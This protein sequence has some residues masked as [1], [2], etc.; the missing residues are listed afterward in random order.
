M[1]LIIL[2]AVATAIGVSGASAQ[3]VPSFP[4]YYRVDGVAAD[5]V[6]NIRAEPTASAPIVG[7]FP[8]DAGPVE[9]L[10]VENGWALV[11]TGEAMGWTSTSYLTE[12]DMPLIGGSS[13]PDGL[14]C[15]GTEPFWSLAFAGGEAIFNSIDMEEAQLSISRAGGFAGVGPFRAYVLASDGQQELTAIMGN[16][17][18]SDGMSDRDYPRTVDLLLGPESQPV[19]YAGCCFVP[20][21]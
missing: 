14:V 8:P 4:G 5:D 1:R 11:S 2:L 17:V 21:Q 18:C 7:T 20:M 12:I 10:R 16:E 6:L 13:L 19:G 3:S 15:A 9:T